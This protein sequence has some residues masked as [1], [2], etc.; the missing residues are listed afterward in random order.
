MH[1]LMNPLSSNEQWHHISLGPRESLEVD[2]SEMAM[3][4]ANWS[5]GDFAF[6]VDSP[7]GNSVSEVLEYLKANPVDAGLLKV[8]HVGKSRLWKLYRHG[9]ATS[10][11]VA[12]CDV[13]DLADIMD[14]SVES[15]DEVKRLIQR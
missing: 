1:K 11:D 5:D 6:I 10:L 12:G 9:L 14:I 7:W 4:A 15:A 13:D 3:L 8:K 2:N